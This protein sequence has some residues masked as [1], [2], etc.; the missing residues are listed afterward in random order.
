MSKLNDKIINEY[1]AN[2]QANAQ[3]KLMT[4]TT[5]EIEGQL[6]KYYKSTM[7][8]IIGQFEQTYNK[9]IS[10]L[11]EGK[12]ATPADLYKLDSYWQLQGQLRS[13]LQKLGD[14]T[15]ALLSRKFEE[16]FKG[17]YDALAIPS[18]T[19]YST[20][21]KHT[22]KQMIN[23]IWCA[24]GK[25]WSSR[26]WT[27]IDKLQQTLNDNLIYCVSAGKKTTE[28][29][30]I[31]QRDFTNISYYQAKS[32]VNTE[33]AHIQTQ[34][35]RQRYKEYGIDEVMIWA[36]YDE[37]RCDECGD[38][39]KTTYKQG[40]HVPLPAHPNCR[41]CIVPVIDNKQPKSYKNECDTCGDMFE[42]F[43]QYITTCPK[44]KEQKRRDFRDKLKHK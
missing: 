19:A 16:H 32:I 5:A 27:N 14:K 10:R 35:A 28:L 1:W 25:T 3:A 38:L 44:C 18:Q 36:D 13:E 31:L 23:E 42:T 4:K 30:K 21:D 26:V 43:N 41:C 8:K 11:D 7:E 17:A 20:L 12:E 15:S 39:H 40:E 33:I 24:D 6:Q 9:V 2:R 37:R 34:A 29:I 22:V